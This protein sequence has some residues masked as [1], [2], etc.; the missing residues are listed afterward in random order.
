MQTK[1][2]F[3][4]TASDGKLDGDKANGFVKYDMYY[5]EVTVVVVYF[6]YPCLLLLDSSGYSELL[7]YGDKIPPSV[8]P[9]CCCSAQALIRLN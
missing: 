3:F 8:M 4:R 7:W 5:S 9:F 1:N 6:N 2:R